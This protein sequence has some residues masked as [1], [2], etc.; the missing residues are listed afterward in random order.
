MS[1]TSKSFR[2]MTVLVAIS[3]AAFSVGFTWAVVDDYGQRAIVPLGAHIEGIDVGG[4]TRAQ[5]TSLVH[6]K[7][8]AALLAPMTLTFQGKTFTLD[9][10]RYVSVDSEGMVDDA[11]RPKTGATLAQRV[12]RRL[13]SEVV[14]TNVTRKLKIDAA[15]LSKWVA[16]TARQVRVPA[17]ESSLTI[18]KD[19]LHVSKSAVGYRLDQRTTVARLTTALRDAERVGVEL[20][21]DTV[22]PIANERSFGKSILVVKHA[23]H[24]YLY[25]GPKL[26]KN[27]PIACGMPAHPTPE[28]W[29]FIEN[30]RYMPSWTNNGSTWAAGMPSYIAPGYNNPLGTRALDLNATGIRIHGTANDGSIGSDASHGCMRMHMWDIE[31]LYDR[32]SVGTRVIIVK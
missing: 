7:V 22:T 9:A 30:K 20:K 4:L 14:Q 12:V 23:T 28:G 24:L 6:D 2:A 17:I 25:D 3:L 18:V 31:D 21:V 27:Y 32:V 11:F 19:R 29:W 10:S 1:G 26:I 15:G 13:T 16:R 5:A 8:E